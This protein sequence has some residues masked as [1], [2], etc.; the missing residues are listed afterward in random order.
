[1][2]AI[3]DDLIIFKQQVLSTIPKV[4][5][6]QAEAVR[7]HIITRTGRG[8]DI[9]G[10]EFAPYVANPRVP[11]KSR[12]YYKFKSGQRQPVTLVKTGRMLSSIRI[13]RIPGGM[14]VVLPRD[15]TKKGRIAQ[16]GVQGKIPA[17]PWWGVT[18][19]FKSYLTREFGRTL[20]DVQTPGDRRRN[21]RIGV[22]VGT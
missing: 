21:F 3:R 20:L 12:Y 1:M 7:K 14:S 17:R 18:P 10:A 22:R 2:D 8:E 13:D 9:T 11:L 5:Q 4:I 19:G 15:A 16:T 6:N